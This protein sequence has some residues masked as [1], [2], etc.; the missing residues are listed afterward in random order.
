MCHVKVPYGLRKH[1]SKKDRYD[2]GCDHTH[3]LFSLDHLEKVDFIAILLTSAFFVELSFSSSG[4][5]MMS[6]VAV[7]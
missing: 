5:T 2:R 4:P 1:K 6:L 3:I 7:I